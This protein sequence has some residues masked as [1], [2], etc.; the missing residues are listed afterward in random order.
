MA[1]IA[2]SLI[3]LTG[4]GRKPT[5]LSPPDPKTATYPQTYPLNP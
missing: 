2:V 3:F 4:C 5:T 1:F